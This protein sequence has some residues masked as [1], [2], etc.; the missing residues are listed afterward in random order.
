MKLL[1]NVILA[2][3]ALVFGGLI[4]LWFYLPLVPDAIGKQ[5][6]SSYTADMRNDASEIIAA[7]S[8]GDPGLL[9]Q[10]RRG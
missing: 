2:V 10:E 6:I 9:L 7:A 1:A 8:R 3:S 4:L 5:W